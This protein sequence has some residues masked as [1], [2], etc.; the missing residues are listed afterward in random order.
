MKNLISILLVFGVLMLAVPA[1]AL[2]KNGVEKQKD[3]T[4][5]YSVSEI[6]EPKSYKMLDTATGEISELSPR[7]YII[8]AVFAQM[9]ASFEPEA[10][11]TQAVIA[12]TYILRQH[13]LE[14]KSPTESLKGADFS[15]DLTT[16]QAYFTPDQAKEKYANDYEEKSEKISSAVDAVLDEVITY[17]GELIFPVFHSMCGGMTESAEIAW[18]TP[19]AYLKPVESKFEAELKGFTEEKNISADEMSA[20]LTQ[21]YKEIELGEDKA[22]WLKI[23]S[24]SPSGTVLALEAGNLTIDGSDFKQ[25]L[26]LRS[27]YYT[28]EYKDES[29]KIVQKG[30]GHGVGLSQYG[31]DEMAKKGSTFNDILTH[32]YTGVKIET[33]KK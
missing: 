2:Y 10:L 9:P 7:E 25:M 29:F 16:Y 15:N 11:K 31:A 5:S 3:N 23:T 24:V 19:F 4:S 32:Y 27:S 12:H 20:R 18:G 33:I 21:N 17:D 26:S 28:V 6:S 8:G 22:S 30:V 1:I 14:L 13:M